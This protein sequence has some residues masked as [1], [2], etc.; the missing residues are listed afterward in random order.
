MVITNA[1]DGIPDVKALVYLDA[2]APAQ[3]E[4]ALGLTGKFPGSVLTSAPTSQVF[5][6]VSYPGAAK[7][8]ALVYVNPWFFMKGSANDLPA[9][10]GA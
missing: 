7:G 6:A 5:R 4:S 8:D 10:E 9:K 3:G 2:F 1:A